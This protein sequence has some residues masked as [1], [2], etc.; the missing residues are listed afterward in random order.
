MDVNYVIKELKVP[1]G[2][3]VSKNPVKFHFE[4]TNGTV[5]LIIQAVED[6]ESR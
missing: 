5:K 1:T 4:E 6:F 2:S 3:Y